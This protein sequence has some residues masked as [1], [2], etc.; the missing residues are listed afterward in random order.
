[1]LQIDE[2]IWDEDKM[3]QLLL[4]IVMVSNKSQ[5][6]AVLRDLLTEKEIEEFA[7]RL[8]IAKLLKAG[9]PYDDIQK[10]VPVSTTTIARI[11]KWLSQGAG[12]YDMVL[13]ALETEYK[14]H[15][16]RTSPDDSAVSAHTS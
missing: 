15:L 9:T 4:A 1:M 14:D 13:R 8:Q 3:Q 7:N 12:G 6:K 11:S 5:A 2:T 16:S 10:Q